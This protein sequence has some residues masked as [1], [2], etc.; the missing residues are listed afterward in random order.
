MLFFNPLVLHPISRAE[1]A[2][3]LKDDAIGKNEVGSVS[4][5]LCWLLETY[6]VFL[7]GVSDPSRFKS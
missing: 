5:L 1:K 7:V 6:D 4:T 3:D 2:F